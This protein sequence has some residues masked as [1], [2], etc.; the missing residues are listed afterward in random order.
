MGSGPG[1]WGLVRET[2]VRARRGFADS[3]PATQDPGGGRLGN[4]PG[5]EELDSR[6]RG[7]EVPGRVMAE[8]PTSERA[9]FT[10][11][12]TVRVNGQEV[13]MLTELTRSM[14]M[15]EAEGGLSSLEL[16]VS[17]LASDT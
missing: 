3:I 14:E 7:R 15:T 16:R 5:A 11:R 9:V 17:N 2:P 6:S 13:P 12:P 8:S 4:G 10:A 1:G